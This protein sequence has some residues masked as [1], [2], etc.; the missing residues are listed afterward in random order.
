MSDYS[1][2]EYLAKLLSF[3]D[4][5]NSESYA[6][7]LT[8]NFGNLNSLMHT[9]CFSLSDALSGNNDAALYIRLVA[10]I[11]SR[12]IA[13]KLKIGKKYLQSDLKEYLV[14]MFFG[15]DI[16][17]VFVLLFD[18]NEKLISVEMLSDGTVNASGFL[19]RKLLDIA[20]RKKAKSVILAHNHPKGET[21]PSRSDVATTGIAERVLRDAGVKLSYHYIVA[22][23]DI[24]DCAR[25]SLE[26]VDSKLARSRKILVSAT[27]T[28]QDN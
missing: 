4:S 9:D 21:V 7:T 26:E 19:P 11:S 2:K 18:E 16:E 10:A 20:I 1:N 6:Q 24:A 8:E 12:R 25:V 14:G 27:D 22:G 28:N 23:F 3:A 5:K 15:Y 17:A 13:D